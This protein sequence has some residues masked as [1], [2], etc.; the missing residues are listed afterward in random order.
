MRVI[1]KTLRYISYSYDIKVFTTTNSDYYISLMDSNNKADIWKHS[2]LQNTLSCIQLASIHQNSWGFLML[3]DDQL[4]VMGQDVSTLTQFHIYKIT[5]STGSY[6][7]GS[8]ISCS[9]DC[10]PTY[11]E[12]LQNSDS[13]KIYSLFLLESS[14]YAY[15]IT[16][17]ATNGGAVDSRY[18]S[19]IS[20]IYLIGSVRNGD[21][22]VFNVCC[23]SNTYVY[24]YDTNSFKFSINKWRSALYGMT[25]EPSTNR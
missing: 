13:S 23:A 18:K 21:N 7:W 5:F 6:N 14:P 19:S 16:L 17:N 24:V 4:F 3:N 22:L 1:L 25:I 12:S 15:F 8:Q 10:S 9:S 2:T 11:A 20:W